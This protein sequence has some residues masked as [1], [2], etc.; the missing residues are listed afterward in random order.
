M[1]DVGIDDCQD[2]PCSNGNLFNYKFMIYYN[3]ID[4]SYD[5]K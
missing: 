1:C 3:Y 5:Y 2:N 4:Y